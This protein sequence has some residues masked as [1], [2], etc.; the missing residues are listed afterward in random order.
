[1]LKELL[2]LHS[3]DKALALKA[4]AARIE[5]EEIFGL[6]MENERSTP[7]HWD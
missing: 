6:E 2:P 5:L 1:M 3:D 4:K 7:H